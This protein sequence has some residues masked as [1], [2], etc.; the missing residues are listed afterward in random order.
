MFFVFVFVFFKKTHKLVNMLQAN[1]NGSG[2]RSEFGARMNN[3]SRVSKSCNVRSPL[4][5]LELKG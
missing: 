4:N 5:S 2:K 1:R 3:N